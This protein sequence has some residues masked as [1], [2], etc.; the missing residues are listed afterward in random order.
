MASQI[1][2]LFDLGGVLIE[3]R[4][5]DALNELL[6][7]PLDKDVLRDRWLHSAALRSFESGL[8]SADDFARRFILEWGLS[9]TQEEFLTEFMAWPS[10]F[11]PGAEALLRELRHN[12]HVSCLS[13]SNALHWEKFNGFAG[14]FDIALSSHLLGLIKPEHDIFI[15]AAQVLAVEP[16]QIL[17]FDDSLSNIKA[18]EETGM[19]SFHVHGLADVISVLKQQD[20][21]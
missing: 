4:A 12:Y 21:L 9:L 18:A 17:F 14:Y 20:I 8:I 19:Q 10:G 5:F 6:P 15:K 11:Y 7:E 1:I 3:N 16:E 13:N 2:I